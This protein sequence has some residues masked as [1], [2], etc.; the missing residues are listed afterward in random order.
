[1]SDLTPMMK[2][3][4]SIKAEQRDAILLF[5][6]GDFYEMFFDDAKIASRVLGLALTTR[7]KGGKNPVPLAGVPHH[8]V[9]SYLARLVEAGYK[10]AIC[11]QVEDPRKAKGLVKRAITEVITPGTLLS[12]SMLDERRSNY[13]L[14]VMPGDTQAGLAR[15][16]L[17]TGEFVVSELA[18]VELRREVLRAEAAE[19]IVPE[20]LV[21]Q[22]SLSTLLRDLTEI[23]V[24]TVADWEFGFNAAHQALTSH[25]G[26]ANL[27][28]FG[29]TGLSEG[30]RA[31]GAAISYLKDLKKRDLKQITTIR[32]LE[33]SNHLV[34]DET[35]QRN[36]ELVEPLERG[37]KH[38]TLLAVLDRTAT[39][40]GA[41][42]LRQ[43]ILYPPFDAD[44]SSSR[45]DGVE[46]LF[47]NRE[48]AEAIRGTLKSLCDL[49]RVMSRV[50]SGHT[51][52]RDLASLK[53]SLEMAPGITALA[54]TLETESLRILVA[55]FPDLTDVTDRIAE[56]LVENPPATLKDGG[57]IRDGHSQEL[58]ALR[59]IT[60]EG[61]DWIGK[62]QI[63]ERSRTGIAS[64]KIGY[65]KVFGYY[66]EVTKTHAHL[67]PD[68]YI[69]KQTLVN[70]ERY[71][72]PDLKEYE[73]RVL[74]AEEDMVKLERDIFEA[75]REW[76]AEHT[77]RV[78]D[79][80]AVL[81]EIDVLNSLADAAVEN[82]YVRPTLANEDGVTIMGGRH[83]VVEVLLDGGTFVPNDVHLDSER[84]QI[85]L[86]T[87]PNM[88]GKSTYLRQVA[89]I[90]IM[91]QMG[92]FVP[93][94]SASIGLIDRIFTRIGAADALARGRS[95]FLVEMSET[96]NILNSATSRSLVLLDEIGRGTSTF[97]GLSIAWAVMEYLHDSAHAHPKTMFATHYH[98]L[99]E[100][101]D[102]LARLKNV[103]VL[104]K[105]TSDSIVFLRKVTPGCADQSYGIEVATLAGMPNDVIVRARE[106][107][108]NLEATQYTPD[109]MPRLAAGEY[110]PLAESS[111][112]LPL[113]GRVESRVEREIREM[114][115]ADM[116]P[117]KALTK[118]AELQKEVEDAE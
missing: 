64:L 99:T 18:L 6:M 47:G 90:V 28:G 12:S 56:T 15:V 85:L 59:S 117:L 93:A 11:D 73:S 112:Q 66:I 103:H 80:A 110:G 36:L 108:R 34:L 44:L 10:V 62:L 54:T 92:S 43:W 102:I 118:L 70:A 32:H 30:I 4:T 60:R 91:A 58:D 33:T 111:T 115:L 95:T 50:A 19:I 49:P 14:S 8:A 2:Q 57:V 45:L 89:L 39:A 38:A 87:G 101:E 25:F 76:I 83:P 65:N 7:D 53:Q 94:E 37:L 88:A 61:K 9:E 35:S 67:V 26:V 48:T 17:S 13:L 98:E 31:A 107:L 63:S 29:L 81:A 51:G 46:A 1:M 22:D 16:D 109:A 96:A 77:A 52:P 100:L 75:L 78:Q 74:T 5:R 21:Q 40:M 113:F 97:D 116:T 84:Q 72:T 106:V 71:V 42:L 23:P 27:D 20:G 104:A 69:R 82:G 68:D 114:D 3:Y 41:R 79:A 86:I 24:T 55:R 105:E